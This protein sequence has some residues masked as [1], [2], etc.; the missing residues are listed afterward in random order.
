V[1]YL[2]ADGDSA[3][4]L[5]AYPGVDSNGDSYTIAYPYPFAD[6]IADAFAYTDRA[7]SDLPGGSGCPCLLFC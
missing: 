5:Y 6:W 3:G 7:N 1:V 4:H 2:H